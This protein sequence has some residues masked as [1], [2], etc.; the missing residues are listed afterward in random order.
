MSLKPIFLVAATAALILST[1]VN[2]ALITIQGDES[3]ANSCIPFGCPDFASYTPHAGFVYQNIGSFT[4]NAGDIIA[5][6]LGAL[7]D[8]EL[9]PFDISLAQTSINGGTEANANGFTTIVSNG[10][11]SGQGNTIIGD[12]DY[13]FTVDNLF[14]F[15]G[16][17]LIIDFLVRDDSVYDGTANHNVV[18][19]A[20]S[21]PTGYFVGRY[22]G[23]DEAGAVDVTFH[24]DI[25]A[26]FELRSIT[27][28]PVPAAV[29]LFGSGLIGLVG[30]ARRK[31]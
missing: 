21:D 9:S 1:S 24:P 2:A 11:G 30:I 8:E 29:W 5:F 20:V 6:D 31:A 14:E 28:V 7:N 22:Y 18:T 23:S 17:G 3:V 10:V 16:G 15:S 19:S 25:A 4:L 26:N 13:A 12:Y 27:V